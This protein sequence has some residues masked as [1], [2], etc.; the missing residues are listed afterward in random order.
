MSAVRS[1]QQ[2]APDRTWL[3]DRAL[4]LLTEQLDFTIGL[5]WVADY[6]NVVLR[7]EQPIVYRCA[8]PALYSDFVGFSLSKQFAPGEGGPGRVWLA[9][10]A[11]TIQNIASDP[12]LPRLL[13]ALRCGLQSYVAFPLVSGKHVHRIFEFFTPKSVLTDQQTL[14]ALNAVGGMMGDYLS[15]AVSP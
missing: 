2:Q 11:I 15:E 4:E 6:D 10:A 3:L 12:S 5:R 7:C 14:N 9:R 8:T 1:L 13:I